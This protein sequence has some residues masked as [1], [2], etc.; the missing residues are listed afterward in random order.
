MFKER[1]LTNLKYI[2]YSLSQKLKLIQYL[3]STKKKFLFQVEIL[4]F[5][6]LTQNRTILKWSPLKDHMLRIQTKSSINKLFLYLGESIL[7][8]VYL[9]TYWEWSNVTFECLIKWIIDNP[10]QKYLFITQK[11]TKRFRDQTTFVILTQHLIKS[12][13][14]LLRWQKIIKQND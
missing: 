10:A 14:F 12:Y 11:K 1:T 7:Q 4:I 6:N 5:Y 3:E 8:C 2:F 9:I 13:I